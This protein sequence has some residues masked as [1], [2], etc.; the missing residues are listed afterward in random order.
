MLTAGLTRAGGGGG[1]PA[2]GLPLRPCAQGVV[3]GSL[4]AR[5]GAVASD[6]EGSRGGVEVHALRCDTQR[7]GGGEVRRRSEE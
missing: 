6:L 3:E 4:H 2:V 1:S 7:E 5:S